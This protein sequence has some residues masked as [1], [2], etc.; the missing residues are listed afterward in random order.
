[1]AAFQRTPQILMTHAGNGIEKLEDMKG[2]GIMISASARSTYWPFFR[3]KYGWTDA[4]IRS[5]SAQLAPWFSDKMAIQQGLVTNEPYLVKR[6]TGEAPTVF[7]LADYGYQSYGSVTTISQALIDK[8]PDVA[9][10]LVQASVKGWDDFLKD[11]KPAFALIQKDDPANTDDLMAAT[12][13]T[14]K[15]A[16]IVE[17][18]DTRKSGFGVITEARWK[19]HFDMLV[20]NGLAKADL[21]WKS[22]L[23]LQFLP[24]KTN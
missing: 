7:L 3:T 10:C 11:P 4:Q 21:D 8:K 12:F 24:A 1:M 16:N 14:L 22:T 6:E 2:K 23:A 18:D 9:R 15:S 20:A 19:E 17:S 5:Y 13:A